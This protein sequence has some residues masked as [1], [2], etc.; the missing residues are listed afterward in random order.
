MEIPKTYYE[1][2]A[3][4]EALYDEKDGCAFYEYLFP[5]NETQADRYRADFSRPNAIFLYQDKRD[6]GTERRLRRHI[7]LSDMWDDDYY[8]YIEN[9]P[10]TLCSGL[11]YRGDHNRLENAQRMNALIFDLDGVGEHEARNLFLRFG[12][13]ANRVRT[14]PM[15]TFLVASGAGLHVY[16]V[17]E[18]PVDLYP[19]IKLQLKALKYDL[20]FR[21]WEYKATST[22]KEIQYQSINQTFRMVG[23]INGKYGNV[24]RAFQTGDKVTLEYLN[25]YVKP[26][27]RVDVNRPFRPSQ[28]TRAQAKEA[29]PEWYQR[30]VVEKGHRLKK[31]DIR[32]K[33]GFALYDW[34]LR[35]I[36]EIKGGHRY[37]FLMC[38]VIY[39]C[40][41]DVPREKLEKDLYAAYEELKLVEHDNVLT[42]EDIK[43][44]LEAYDKEYYNFTIADIEKLTDIRIKRN[45]RNGQKQKDHLEEARAIRDIRMKRQNRDWRQGNGRPKGSGTAEAAIK[46]FLLEHPTAS[47]AEVIRGTGKDKKTVYKYYEAAKQEAA[48]QIGGEITEILPC[49]H[50]EDA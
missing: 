9:N 12:E 25:Q 41:C 38:V 33:Q 22:K 46:A 14:L 6:R 36:G 18:Q 26:E 24:I 37:Y 27:K 11:S 13:P 49:P 48:A 7:M 40:K 1:L 31:W 47:K 35:Q 23:S 32:S 19:N 8:E 3:M 10:L 29:Y 39:A 21:M 5:D 15:P 28:I 50:G 42:E 43:S 17:F 45:K 4:L 30:V 2:T 16:Y 34:W 44:A 20:T